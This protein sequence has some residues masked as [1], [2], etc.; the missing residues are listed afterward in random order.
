MDAV[1]AAAAVHGFDGHKEVSEAD[2]VAGLG[3]AFECGGEESG[4]GG[5]VGRFEAVGG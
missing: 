4:D 5:G 1:D 2:L 3:D